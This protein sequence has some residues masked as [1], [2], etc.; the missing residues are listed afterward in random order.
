MMETESLD[1]LTKCHK[2][3]LVEK[4]KVDLK[5]QNMY[6]PKSACV[7]SSLKLPA[8]VTEEEVIVLL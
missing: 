1:E 4:Y 3:R 6:K 8:C 5:S 2:K 7:P